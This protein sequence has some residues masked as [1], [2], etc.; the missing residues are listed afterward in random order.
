[1]NKDIICQVPAL[2]GL[3]KRPCR[4]QQ[5]PGCRGPCRQ[6][7]PLCSCVSGWGDAPG[8]EGLGQWGPHWQDLKAGGWGPR[9]TSWGA[10]TSGF[11]SPQARTG[12]PFQ[13]HTGLWKT[14][15]PFISSW[16]D[17]LS[18]P[19]RSSE[20]LRLAMGT[21]TIPGRN[22]PHAAGKCGSR[23]GH[24]HSCCAG[25]RRSHGGTGRRAGLSRRALWLSPGSRRK[26]LQ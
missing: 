12:C 14:R 20:G 25:Q 10:C 15:S 16:V 1:M 8:R 2:V 26:G 23:G 13:P 21:G 3:G 18:R 7:Q 19:R 24:E 17:L 11:L 22:S 4:A 9:Q 6:P 5:G